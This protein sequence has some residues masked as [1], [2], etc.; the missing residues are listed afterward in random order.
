MIACPFVREGHPFEPA[1]VQ[2]R[3]ALDTPRPS[4]AR[5]ARR[6]VRQHELK[7]VRGANGGWCMDRFYASTHA[8]D[9]S[10]PVP[11]HAGT[12]YYSG[13]TGAGEWFRFPSEPY[14]GVLDYLNEVRDAEVLQYVV[15]RRLTYRARSEDG[16]SY[17]GKFKRRSRARGAFDVLSLVST[18]ARNAHVSFRVPAPLQF[19]SVRHH[20]LQEAVAGRPVSDLLREDTLESLLF[21]VGRIHAELHGLAVPDLPGADERARIERL[22]QNCD[23]VGFFRPSDGLRL[24]R[25]RDILLEAGRRFDA[26]EPVT[27]HGDF[28]PSHV[29]LGPGGRAVVDFDLAHRGDPHADAALLLASLTQDV[30]WLRRLWRDS[31]AHASALVDRAASAYVAGYQSFGGTVLDRRRLLWHRIAAEI[32]M[33]GLVLTKDRFDQVAFDR[34]MHLVEELAAALSSARAGAA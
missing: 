19:D 13:A 33:L 12:Y 21:G 7:G 34:S 16:T 31:D 23:W 30:P 18:A 32:H 24:A 10:R 15:L 14:L 1:M 11:F 22:L 26:V 29:L 27:C 25:V 2:I 3:R 28:V 20:F 6:T 17:I 9:D 8:W 5:G 4:R